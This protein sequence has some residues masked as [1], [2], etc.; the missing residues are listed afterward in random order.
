M[1]LRSG[2]GDGMVGK[3]LADYGHDVTLADFQDW[4]DPRAAACRYFKAIENR[5]D[6]PGSQHQPH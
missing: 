6:L 4:R 3:L 2:A 1:F 5:I